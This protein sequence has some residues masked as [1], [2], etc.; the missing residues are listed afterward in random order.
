MARKP[1]TPKYTEE[2]MLGALIKHGDN[3][4]NYY[5]EIKDDWAYWI[6]YKWL[7]HKNQYALPRTEAFA[8]ANLY[9]LSNKSP[10]IS[11]KLIDWNAQQNHKGLFRPHD[12]FL[13][14]SWQREVEVPKAYVSS[15][16]QQLV[17]KE[18]WPQKALESPGWCSVASA[19][20][21]YDSKES[22]ELYLSET[23]AFFG[24]LKPGNFLKE[25]EWE[26]WR[27][28]IAPFDFGINPKDYASLSMKRID[29]HI[30]FHQANEFSVKDFMLRHHK[31]EMV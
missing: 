7:T 23:V 13:W 17:L 16:H 30:K 28:Q 11:G 6:E 25:Q 2:E 22:Y 19:E 1:F 14:S 3:L 18:G 8:I 12:L 9:E 4:I 5:H 15:Y 21:K 26:C 29:L 20:A 10:V 27:N 31:P 24:P